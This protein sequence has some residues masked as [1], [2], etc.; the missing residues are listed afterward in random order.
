MINLKDFQELSE[1]ITE[2]KKRYDYFFSSEE[3]N[4]PFHSFLFGG[5]YVD[6]CRTEEK[7]RVVYREDLFSCEELL[8]ILND[9]NIFFAPLE[10][11]REE[12]VKKREGQRIL[13]KRTVEEKERAELRRLLKKYPEEKKWLKEKNLKDAFL[14][15]KVF[16]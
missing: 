11:K 10:K 16:L 6:L 9:T 7:S 13:S 3:I 5:N 1:K 14:P 2:F 15:L 8:N 12:E 4:D